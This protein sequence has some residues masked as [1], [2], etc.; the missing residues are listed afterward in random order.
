M[1]AAAPK[2]ARRVPERNEE[3]TVKQAPPEAERLRRGARRVGFSIAYEGR[4]TFRPHL[5]KL[6]VQT[7]L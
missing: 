1:E 2:T 6:R 3:R 4:N 5:G 7:N